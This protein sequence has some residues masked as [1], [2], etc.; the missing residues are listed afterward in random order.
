MTV[1]V[2]VTVVHVFETL[3]CVVV[4][5]VV[6]VVLL[7][8]CIYFYLPNKRKQNTAHEPSSSLSSL[9]RVCVLASLASV[10]ELY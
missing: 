9:G 2:T 10:V 5:V 1:T 4:V 8:C 6:V 3:C 7:L